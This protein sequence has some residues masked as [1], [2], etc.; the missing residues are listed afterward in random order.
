MLPNLEQ[1][2]YREKYGDSLFYKVYLYAMCAGLCRDTQ[3]A[4]TPAGVELYPALYL[5]V[6]LMSELRAQTYQT[7][8]HAMVLQRLAHAMQAIKE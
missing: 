1:T 3:L 7:L 5:T 4:L 2:L 6:L 8:Y